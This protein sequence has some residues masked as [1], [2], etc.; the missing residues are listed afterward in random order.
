[1]KLSSG[2]RFVLESDCHALFIPRKFICNFRLIKLDKIQRNIRCGT[3]KIQYKHSCCEASRKMSDSTSSDSSSSTGSEIEE[4]FLRACR[5][6]DI[7]TVTLLLE[8]RDSGKYGF[9]VSCKGKS[10]SNLGW[11][12]LHLATYFGHRI[13]MEVLL[14]AGA[15][16]NAINDSGDTPLHKAA[17]IGREVR[18]GM[19]ESVLLPVSSSRRLPL[20][21]I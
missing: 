2:R 9:D 5:N 10:K 1:M 17:F 3:S 14:T 6:G 19:R 7:Q 11:T 20:F 18:I 13:V 21:S 15:D 12:P 4:I 16:I 8:K